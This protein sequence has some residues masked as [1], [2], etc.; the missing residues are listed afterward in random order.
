MPPL[1]RCSGRRT[2]DHGFDEPTVAF[3]TRQAATE[4]AH[5][6]SAITQGDFE[7]VSDVSGGVLREAE[8]PVGQSATYMPPFSVLAEIHKRVFVQAGALFRRM[9]AQYISRLSDDGVDFKE[10]GNR[11]LVASIGLIVCLLQLA[12]T[13]PAR[14]R[15]AQDL[16]FL[17]STMSMASVNFDDVFEDEGAYEES[18]KPAAMSWDKFRLKFDFLCSSVENI[19]DLAICEY[20]QPWLE[21]D[22]SVTVNEFVK[23]S[24]AAFKVRDRWSSATNRDDGPL[25]RCDEQ[26]SVIGYCLGF[27]D[28]SPGFSRSNFQGPFEEHKE[29][30]RS[31]GNISDSSDHCFTHARHQNLK[32]RRCGVCKDA[33]YCSKECQ[34]AAWSNGHRESCGKDRFRVEVDG[35]EVWVIKVF[36]AE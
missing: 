9:V 15:I 6:V 12:S 10:M 5:W 25:R 21:M 36:D 28:T 35:S 22:V 32:L 29:G 31:I 2:S 19:L 20:S 27:K 3:E 33:R 16:V 7:V 24:K 11:H 14:K 4:A 30:I 23:L 17:L 18:E 34:R 13:R 26:I 1:G 8:L